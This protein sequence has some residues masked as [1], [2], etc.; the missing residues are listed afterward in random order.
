MEN[1]LD[2]TIRQEI[3]YQGKVYSY[4]P[5]QMGVGLWSEKTLKGLAGKVA[6]KDIQSALNKKVFGYEKLPNIEERMRSATEGQKSR[7]KQTSVEWLQTKIALLKA[8]QSVIPDS[9]SAA[10]SRLRGRMFFY[11][12]DPKT[13]DSLPMWDKFPLVIILE[14]YNDGFLG[15]NLHYVSVD[16]RTKLL[17]SLL[18]NRIYDP[19][20]NVLKVNIDYERIV[21]YLKRYPLFKDC[22]KRYLGSH[23]TGRTLEIKPHEWGLAIVLPSEEFQYNKR[24][25]VKK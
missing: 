17:M 2:Y 7:M 1:K 20:N 13:K 15:L 14:T 12:Y 25:Q 5:F 8:G 22:I 11:E 21:I 18:K 6:T 23:I 24:K 16:N 4:N 19:E 10:I 3:E 9:G